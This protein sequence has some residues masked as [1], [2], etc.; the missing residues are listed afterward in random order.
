M[1]CLLRNLDAWT[2]GSFQEKVSEGIVKCV[3]G[4]TAGKLML[5]AWKAVEDKRRDPLNPLRP[6]AKLTMDML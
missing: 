5:D 3:D 6:S 2:E 1:Y 4:V